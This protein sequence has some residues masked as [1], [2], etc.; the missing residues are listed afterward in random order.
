MVRMRYSDADC[1][2]LLREIALRLAGTVDVPTAGRLAAIS[3]ATC[4][5][6]RSPDP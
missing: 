2:E 6:S 3:G 4:F 5:N 1:L